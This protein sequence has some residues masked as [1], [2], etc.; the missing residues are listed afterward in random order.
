MESLKKQKG[1][2]FDYYICDDVSTDGTVQA[3]KK[4]APEAHILQGTGNLFWTKGMYRAMQEAVKGE[5]DYYLMVN[6]DV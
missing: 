1:V 5:Y 3:I 6:D 2:Q 4:L